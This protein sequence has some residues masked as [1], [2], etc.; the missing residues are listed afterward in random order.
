M[1]NQVSHQERIG[2]IVATY[3]ATAD[4]FARNQIDFC[5]G[6]GQT[7]TQAAE[8]AGL[9]VEALMTE[10]RQTFQQKKDYPSLSW[11]IDELVHHIVEVHHAYIREKSPII[12]GYLERVTTVHGSRHPNLKEVQRLFNV[13]VVE[14]DLHM[15]FE[16][17]SVFPLCLLMEKNNVKANRHFEQLLAIL[18]GD[19]SNE[20]ERFAT[21]S[22][23]T[24]QYQVPED[25]CATF[26]AAYAALEDFHVQLIQ[27]VHLENN[28][29]SE[30]IASLA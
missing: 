9:S 8:Q 29:L 21:I 12:Q 11:T 5:C 7:L 19:H 10:L 14:M 16:E 25:A 20:G 6:G 4:V 18:K 30:K 2:H 1:Q 24:G 23:L 13:S 27:H 22:N 28:V 3:P 17:S 15:Q 26:R